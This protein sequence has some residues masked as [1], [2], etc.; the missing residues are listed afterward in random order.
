MEK[1]P[2]KLSELLEAGHAESLEKTW[3][4]EKILRNL[5]YEGKASLGKNVREAGEAQRFFND[6][7]TQ[8]VQF[9]EEVVFPFLKTHVPRLEPMIWLL[10]AEHQ[11][12]RIN[13]EF[14]KHRLEELM[15]GRKEKERTRILE[16]LQEA[17]F[18]L[19]YLLRT[20]M[21]AESQYLHQ[22]VEKELKREEKQELIRKISRHSRKESRG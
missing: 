3:K 13:L 14:F 16:K 11:D 9:E 20:H 1:L 18:Y 6:E 5:R 8:H 12:F 7:L 21:R 17:G 10:Q 15:D 2:Y 4:L 19:I 22:V